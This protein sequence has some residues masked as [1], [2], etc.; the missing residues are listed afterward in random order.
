MVVDSERIRG[1]PIVRYSGEDRMMTKMFAKTLRAERPS[2]IDYSSL[3]R[4]SISGSL[5]AFPISQDL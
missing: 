4:M 3:I 1:V 5:P 2:E